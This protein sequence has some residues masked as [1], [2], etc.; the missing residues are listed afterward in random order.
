MMFKRILV[1]LDGSP[2]AERALPVAARLARASGGSIVLLQVVNPPVE[3]EMYVAQP[4]VLIEQA[5]TQA[6]HYLTCLAQSDELEGIGIQIEVMSGSVVPTLFTSAQSFGADLIVL[7]SH[8]Y[9]GFKR[10]VLGSVADRVARHAPAPVL[11]LRESGPQPIDIPS[12][13]GSPLRAL[14]ALDGSALAEA[15]LTPAAELVAALAAPEQGALHLVRVVDIPPHF[16]AGKSQANIGMEMIEQA[17]HEAKAYLTSVIDQFQIGIAA[18][19]NLS[20]NATVASDTDVAGAIIKEG[21]HAENAEEYAFMALSTHGRAGVQRWAMGSITERV[22][23]GTKL[24]LLIVRPHQAATMKETTVA[25]S[26]DAL[27]SENPTWVG[28]L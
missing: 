13:T 2:R 27:K 8:G 14:V 17:K 1:P 24:P 15:A 9:T 25:R 21:E 3:Y 26:S 16:G 20:L 5:I 23:H 10:W 19:L 22:L 11:V 4:S 18:R 28:L 6:I 7:C 12:A